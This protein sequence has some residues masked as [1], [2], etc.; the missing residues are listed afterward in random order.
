MQMAGPIHYTEQM[1]FLIEG[2]VMA[3]SD[4][5]CYERRFL[6]LSSSSGIDLALLKF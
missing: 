1:G 6:Q 4:R 3:Q 2:V 5:N